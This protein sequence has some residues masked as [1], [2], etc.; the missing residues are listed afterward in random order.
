MWTAARS[1]RSEC[2]SKL[3]LPLLL[4]VIVNVVAV[5]VG[6]GVAV[7]AVVAVAAVI[8]VAVVVVAVVVASAVGVDFCLLAFVVVFVLLATVVVVVA[9]VV[10]FVATIA[11]VAKLLGKLL[12]PLS[13]HPCNQKGRY[14]WTAFYSKVLADLCLR[15]C[16]LEPQRDLSTSTHSPT[17]Q[18]ITRRKQ[19]CNNTVFSRL[20]LACARFHDATEQRHNCFSHLLLC[21]RFIASMPRSSGT[22]CSMRHVIASGTVG[23]ILLLRRTFVSMEACNAKFAAAKPDAQ[24][25][26]GHKLHANSETRNQTASKSPQAHTGK[27][28]DA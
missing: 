24:L 15:A 28:A 3:L 11:A 18:R 16:K 13:R 25:L 21:T 4:L 6:V 12:L 2:P 20:S 14:F 1:P 26:H 17:N 10:V 9:I 22:S 27:A 7:V 8:V 19:M 23:P 5:T